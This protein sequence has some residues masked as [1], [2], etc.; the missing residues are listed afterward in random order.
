MTCSDTRKLSSERDAL[1]SSIWSISSTTTR[2]LR[3]SLGMHPL[4]HNDA[5][6]TYQKLVPLQ[7]EDANVRFNFGTALFNAGKY[8]HAASSYREAIRLNPAL[9]H[10]HYNLA[11]A[12]LRLNDSK[13]AQ[14]EFTEAHRLDPTLNPPSSAK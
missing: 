6:A 13:S 11:M 14:A 7:P 12:L 4:R 2:H 5:I 8:Q 10:A 3:I 1:I 9:A